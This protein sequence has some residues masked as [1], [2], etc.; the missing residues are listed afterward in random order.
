MRPRDKFTIV[1]AILLMLALAAAAAENATLRREKEAHGW[2][3]FTCRTL[4][5][6]PQTRAILDVKWGREDRKF[7][8]DRAQQIKDRGG[9]LK[10]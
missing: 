10:K 6:D 5:D 1:L 9:E 8:C 3:Y 4:L 2:R 7:R